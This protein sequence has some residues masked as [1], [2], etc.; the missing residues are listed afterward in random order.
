M[1]EHFFV[2]LNAFQSNLVLI[3]LRSLRASE[4]W[5]ATVFPAVGRLSQCPF[6][7]L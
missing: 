7:P 2:D 1:L 6:R 5:R 3:G 4:N